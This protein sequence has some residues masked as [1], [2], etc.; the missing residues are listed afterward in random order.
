MKIAFCISGQPR[1]SRLGHAGIQ[2]NIIDI[3]LAK[4]FGVDI[5]IHS[6][7]E[8]TPALEDTTPES[9]LEDEKI[10]KNCTPSFSTI[11]ESPDVLVDLYKPS[12]YIIEKQIPFDPF[13]YD[14]PKNLGWQPNGRAGFN[15]QSMFYSIWA[16][17]NL[18][19]ARE[20]AGGFTYDAVV[21]IRPDCRVSY[22]V[23]VS[24][25]DL[26]KLYHRGDTPPGCIDRRAPSW[27]GKMNDHFA[28]SNSENMN[29]YSD[30]YLALDSLYD[31]GVPFN[32]E[33]TLGTWVDRNNIVRDIIKYNELNHSVASAIIR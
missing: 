3:N 27:P 20:V 13:K 4:G 15:Q 33:F 6:W 18:K 32:P 17:N 25:L 8:R 29:I 22:P 28:I 30:C 16:A 31:S 11:L 7:E 14:V 19:R 1:N 26:K 9:L 24:K 2:K 12:S 10:G 5:F 21:R 23:D